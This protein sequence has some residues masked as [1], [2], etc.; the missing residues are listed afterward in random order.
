MLAIQ[1]AGTGAT[2]AFVDAAR[3]HLPPSYKP[4]SLPALLQLEAPRADC[5]TREVLEVCHG[6]NADSWR[7][8]ASGHALRLSAT[9][10]STTRSSERRDDEGRRG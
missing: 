5:G 1:S 3:V 2:I 6:W 4:L 8:I 9:E 10:A 7:A